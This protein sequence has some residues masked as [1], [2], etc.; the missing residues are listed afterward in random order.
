MINIILCR[1]HSGCIKLR[2]CSDSAEI[3]KYEIMFAHK[4]ENIYKKKTF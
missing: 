3:Q 4:K 1:T 2:L